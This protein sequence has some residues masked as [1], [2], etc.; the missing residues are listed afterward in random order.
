MRLLL[1]D[2]LEKGDA[3]TWASYHASSQIMSE[4][5]STALTQLMLLFYEKA[6]SAAMVKHGMNVP[7]QAIEFLNPGQNSSNCSLCT[8]LC[9][10]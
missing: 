1:K 6:A 3:V 4:D 7:R 9:N 10:S 8:T 5:T 2:E